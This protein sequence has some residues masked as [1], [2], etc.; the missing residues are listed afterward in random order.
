MF[1]TVYMFYPDVRKGSR[2]RERDGMYLSVWTQL[3]FALQL[4]GGESWQTICG[5]GQALADRR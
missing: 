3:S 1:H 4:Q 5:S 2:A